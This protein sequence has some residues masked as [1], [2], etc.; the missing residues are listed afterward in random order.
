MKCLLVLLS[1]AALTRA[2]EF[3]ACLCGAFIT[4]MEEEIE[5]FRLPPIEVADCD[6]TTDCRARCIDEWTTIT[7]DGDLD[8]TWL[9]GV[10]IGQHMCDSLHDNDHSDVGPHEVY[11]YYNICLGPW[12]YTG[13]TSRNTLCCSSSNYLTCPPPPTVFQN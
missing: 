3:P 13:Q 9:D 2:Q 6:A 12:I 8:Y 7:E 4:L 1:L 5:V 11:L 10:T